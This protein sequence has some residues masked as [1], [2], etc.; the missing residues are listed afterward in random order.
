MFTNR[1]S[2]AQ[3]HRFIL[4]FEKKSQKGSHRHELEWPENFKVVYK[5]AHRTIKKK[6]NNLLHEP[7][8]HIIE[9]ESSHSRISF[10][11]N[12]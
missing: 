1:V 12:H 3:T 4:A 9:S 7:S 6:L 2:D 8:L 11:V 10:A 5:I